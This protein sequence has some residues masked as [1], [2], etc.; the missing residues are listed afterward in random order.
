MFPLCMMCYQLLVIGKK[1]QFEW[2]FSESD[3]KICVT[4]LKNLTML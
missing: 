2:S 1:S 4:C 3:L